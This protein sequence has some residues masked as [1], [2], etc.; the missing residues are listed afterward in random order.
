MDFLSGREGHSREG[1]AMKFGTVAGP[2]EVAM[3]AHVVAAHCRHAGITPGTVEHENIAAAI[4]GLYEM[5]F[6]GE[7][8]LLAALIAPPVPGSAKRP[9]TKA[10]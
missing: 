9:T 6:R 8:E 10:A 5:G 1:M 4:F 7:S 3:M 2:H